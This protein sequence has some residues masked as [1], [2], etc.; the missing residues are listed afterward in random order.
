MPG[1]GGRE[2]AWDA[3]SRLPLLPEGVRLLLIYDGW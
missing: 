1:H 2:P 3:E